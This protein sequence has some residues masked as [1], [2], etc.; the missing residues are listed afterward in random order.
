[1]YDFEMISWSIYFLM[2]NCGCD[3]V[4]IGYVAFIWQFWI[5]YF[6]IF[7]CVGLGKLGA[8]FEDEFLQESFMF[9]D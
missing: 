7:P 1:M 6:F 3:G 5:Y 9:F 8:F 4:Y 2:M